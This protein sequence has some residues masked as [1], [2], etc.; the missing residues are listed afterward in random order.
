MVNLLLRGVGMAFQ[1]YLSG[2]IGAD[3]IGLLQLTGTVNAFAM[4]LGLS[5]V[6]VAVMYLCAEEYGRRNPAGMR[7][8]LLLCLAYGAI[9]SSAVGIGLFA[10]AGRIAEG[11]MHAPALAGAVRVSALTLPLSCACA[12][13][14][15]YYTASDQVRTLVRIEVLERF[16]SLGVTFAFLLLWAGND[17]PRACISIALGGA[18]AGALTV[19]LLLRRFFRSS[20]DL[21]ASAGPLPTAARLIRLCI[22]LALNDYLRSGLSTL[23]HFLIPWGLARSGRSQTESMAAYGTIHGMVFPVLMFPAALLYSMADLLIPALAR[24]RARGDQL[25]IYDL[26]DRCLRMCLLFAGFTAGLCFVLSDALGLLIYH[27]AEA[28]RYLR[29]FS[30]MVLI[31]Y[32][33]ALVDGMH[34]GLGQQAVNVR[35]NTLTSFLDVLLLFLLLPRCGIGAYVFSFVV[36]HAVNFCLS[37]RRLILVT[38]WGMTLSSCI[39]SLLC[40]AA[41]VLAAMALP[42]YTPLA[43]VFLRAPVFA[44]VFFLF[45]RLGAL[46]TDPDRAWLCRTFS[47]RH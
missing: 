20:A 45:I 7:R 42:A 12:I 16:V 27:S 38:D 33:D 25:R 5:G 31:L 32:M 8:V 23:E 11:W 2:R 30:P 10:L 4:T 46:F 13:L 39:R 36:T 41:A 17:T 3:G 29:I 47:F 43:A 37:L 14:A 9:V 35:Y 1:A 40:P 15:G 6:R 18:L 26:T 21:P 28:G 24:L 22:P 44:A 34:K 19:F